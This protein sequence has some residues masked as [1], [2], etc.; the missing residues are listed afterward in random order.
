MAS[1]KWLRF[2]DLAD[3]L[4]TATGLRMPPIQRRPSS[5]MVARQMLHPRAA[6]EQELFDAALAR[7]KGRFP[8]KDEEFYPLLEVLGIPV[9]RLHRLRRFSSDRRLRHRK[10]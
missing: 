7:W 8:R 2:T 1:D 6:T 10:V 9:R 5:R 3:L 4:H